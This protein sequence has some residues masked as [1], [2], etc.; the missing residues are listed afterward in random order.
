M[1]ILT[2]SLATQ[3][4]D[5]SVAPVELARAA[6][7]YKKSKQKSKNLTR[8]V[9]GLTLVLILLVA[10]IVGKFKCTSAR[11]RIT[12]TRRARKGKGVGIK[13]PRALPRYDRPGHRDE[14]GNDH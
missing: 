13:H 10:A 11:R 12:H 8:A 4:G 9:A 3:D 2:S 14:Q 7:L 5:G 6:E 1:Q